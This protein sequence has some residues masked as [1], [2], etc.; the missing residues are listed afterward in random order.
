[1]VEITQGSKE[2]ITSL[3]TLMA[4][5]YQYEKGLDVI[6]RDGC[7]RI[8]LDTSKEGD[9][10]C[11][12]QLTALAFKPLSLSDSRQLSEWINEAFSCRVIKERSEYEVDLK[13][14]EVEYCYEWER[15]FDRLKEERQFAEDEL[16]PKGP[17][18]YRILFAYNSA[19]KIYVGER[20]R[21]SDYED[22]FWVQRKLWFDYYGPEECVETGQ[23]RYLDV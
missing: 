6:A 22:E 3:V 17:V 13:I 5:V 11:R 14:S 23:I 1:M 10:Y 8:E 16:V 12:A 9:R 21:A 4:Q 18:H 7:S 20:L 2:A 19:T 15:N